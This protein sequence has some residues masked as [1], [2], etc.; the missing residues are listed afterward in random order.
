MRQG[1][2]W[3]ANQLAGILEEGEDGYT[4]TYLDKYL[5][6][7]NPLPVSL[8]LP[9]QTESYKSETLFPFF[10]GL[11]PEGW[12]LDVAHQNWKLNPRDRMGLLLKTCRD[13]IG[14]ISVIEI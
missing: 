2:I 8:T 7:K 11:I 14:N 6:S 9:L 4:F 12:L 5:K 1:E 3:V 13:C 10:D